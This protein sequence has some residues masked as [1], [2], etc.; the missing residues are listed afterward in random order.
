M[1]LSE[2]C[3]LINDWMRAPDYA[4]KFLPR[5]WTR[6]IN[7]RPVDAM[8][9]L[10]A[11]LSDQVVLPLSAEQELKLARS[12]LAECHKEIFK[13][14]ETLVSASTPVRSS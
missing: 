5:D 9:R 10:T 1:T 2:D 6:W 12:Q 3:K 14:R 4:E 13:L 7:C 11:A 8:T